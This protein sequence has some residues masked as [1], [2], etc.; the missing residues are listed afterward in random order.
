M[1]L[2]IDVDTVT[3]VLLSDGWHDVAD[4]TF[5]LDAYEFIY[6]GQILHGGGNGGV[7]STGFNFKEPSGAWLCGPLTAVLAVQHKRR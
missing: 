7:C 5:V 4:D 2:A 6:G 1:S 3:A